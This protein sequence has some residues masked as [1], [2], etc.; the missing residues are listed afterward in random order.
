MCTKV[1]VECYK[2]GAS[3]DVEIPCLPFQDER[4]ETKKAECPICKSDCGTVQVSLIIAYPTHL[5]AHGRPGR[6]D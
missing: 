6:T 1:E 2:C 4:T 3:F 5:A